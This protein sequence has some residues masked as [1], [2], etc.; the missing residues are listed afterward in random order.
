MFNHPQIPQDMTDFC[1][2][3]I[4]KT[5]RA[6]FR[7]LAPL[8]IVAL[9]V[10]LAVF[11]VDVLN[12]IPSERMTAYIVVVAAYLVFI[13]IIYL[14]FR[15]GSLFSEERFS[16]LL[17]FTMF[18]SLLWTA[19]LSVLDQNATTFI[20]ATL[21][22]SVAFIIKPRIYLYIQVSLLVSLMIAFTF[23]KIDGFTLQVN[24]INMLLSSFLSSHIS[25]IIYN[26]SMEGVANRRLIEIKNTELSGLVS[27]LRDLSET[28]ALTTLFNR[29]KFNETANVEW[30][31]ALR[32]GT[33]LVLIILDVDYFKNYNDS[34]GHLRGDDCLSMIALT[35]RS[36]FQRADEF[37]ARYGGEE[38]AIIMSHSGKEAGIIACER[39]L[40][41]VRAQRIPHN[42]STVDEFITV[43]AGMASTIPKSGDRLEEFINRADLA[44]YRAKVS[45]RN[46]FIVAEEV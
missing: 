1:M 45:G 35:L 27:Q 23:L 28:D 13:T 29:R 10:I 17:L 9:A 7:Y 43:S 46:Q 19:A 4:R 12:E 25:R 41:A 5:N 18:V 15:Q 31:K 32:N 14:L 37:V 11:V 44:L 2:D 26:T 36:I 33:G 22:F 8:V 42:Q 38:F 6:R 40:E 3:E 24:L 39:L 34:Y 30:R 16:A 20:M 21:L